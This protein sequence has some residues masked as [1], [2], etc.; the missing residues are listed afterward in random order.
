V[1]SFES[2][3]PEGRPLLTSRIHWREIYAPPAKD[4][5]SILFELADRAAMHMHGL[6]RQDLI[7][8]PVYSPDKHRWL[9]W[10]PHERK[11][12]AYLCTQGRLLYALF[13]PPTSFANRR[14][15]RLAAA[16]LQTID[17]MQAARQLAL[18]NK[19]YDIEIG[20]Q[21]LAKVLG[22]SKSSLYRTYEKLVPEAL[23]YARKHAKSPTQLDQRNRE[24]TA[25]P[26]LELETEKEDLNALRQALYGDDGAG[27]DFNETAAEIDD[28]PFEDIYNAA[29]AVRRAGKRLGRDALKARLG[30]RRSRSCSDAD[31]DHAIRAASVA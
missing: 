13:K 18:Y 30:Q 6:T 25:H 31:L 29:L 11:T 1:E 26:G 15:R 23:R 12:N 17:I 24:R 4:I 3:E 22:M 20:H 10:P 5:L 28:I 21:T 27:G 19:V 8:P 7:N 2:C 14:V 16:T 9:I